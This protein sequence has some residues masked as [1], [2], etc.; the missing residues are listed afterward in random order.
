[1][2]KKELTLFR[3]E[4]NLPDTEIKDLQKD[5]YKSCNQVTLQRTQTKSQEKAYGIMQG[6]KNG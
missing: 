4:L 1:M 6:A 5:L 2:K 3:T